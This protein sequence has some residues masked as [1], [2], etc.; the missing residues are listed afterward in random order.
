MI[1]NTSHDMIY[2]VTRHI[3]YPV[4]C[5]KSNISGFGYMLTS[6]VAIMASSP[7]FVEK[8]ALAVGLTTTGSGIGAF[9][10]PPILRGLFDAFGFSGALLIYG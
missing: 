2:H 9:A 1:C 7:Y 6:F 5:H 10:I 4:M 3:I 8:K